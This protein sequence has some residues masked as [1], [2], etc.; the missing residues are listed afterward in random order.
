MAFDMLNQTAILELDQCVETA[1]HEMV[2]ASNGD[3]RNHM[4]HLQV[5][6]DQRVQMTRPEAFEKIE[7][8]LSAK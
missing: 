5:L 1:I 7:K 3:W 2:A 8:L 6:I 4:A